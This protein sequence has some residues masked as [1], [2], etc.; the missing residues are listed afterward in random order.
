MSQN[1][2]VNE[3]P[4]TKRAKEILKD[5]DD[6]LD[7]PASISLRYHHDET[8]RSHI[9]ECAHIMNHLCDAYGIGGTDRDMLVACCYVHDIGKLNITHKGFI[10]GGI[11]EGWLYYEASGWSRIE[12]KMKQHPVLGAE[13]L[14]KNEIPRKEEITRII[15]CHMSHWY[16]K[17][18]QPSTMYEYMM[19]TADYTSTYKEEMLKYKGRENPYILKNE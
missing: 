15:S 11:K 6:K 5:F 3:D 12:K 14:D 2:N 13:L 7:Q 16:P 1:E 10:E 9:E 18:P 4:I 19:I 8:M 17:M